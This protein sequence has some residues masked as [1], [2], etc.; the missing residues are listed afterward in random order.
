MSV[1]TANIRARTSKS[2]VIHPLNLPILPPDKP[3]E[4][5]SVKE[6]PV[7]GDWQYEPKWDGFR[8]LVF[9]D[10]R[11]LELQSKSGRLLTR[12]FP[13]LVEALLD[14][15]A[16]RFV[17][18][19]EIAVPQDG[20]FSFD[21]LLE[22]IHPAQ[23]RVRRLAAETPAMLIVF[24]L[25]AGTDGRSL[26]HLSLRKRRPRLDAFAR[27]YLKGKTRIHLSPATT[28]LREARA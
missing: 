1:A 6:I 21:A 18:D 28:R 5:L 24:D 23:S 11:K 22:R 3:M 26:T 2:K 12:Y 17:I 16:D 20:A 9:R 13:E 19:G 8:C 10:G 15:Q 7:E 25:L 14:V 4:A 27:R